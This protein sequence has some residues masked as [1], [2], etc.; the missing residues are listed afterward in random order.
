MARCFRGRTCPYRFRDACSHDDDPE[1]D[2]PCRD[3]AAS[4]CRVD[5]A[6]ARDLLV[7]VRR[8]ERIVEQIRGVLVP[9][10]M[11]GDVDGFVG[12]QIGAVPVP[13]I[14]EPIGERV[15]NCF[16]EQIVGV[17]VPQIMEAPVDVMLTTPQERVQ[18]RTHEQIV[19][20]SVPHIS[21]ERVPNRSPE[22]IMDFPVSLNM[23]A[24]AGI[25]RDI[26]LECVQNRSFV[27]PKRVFV[28]FLPPHSALKPYTGKVF[29]VKL[30]HHRDDRSFLDNVGFIR[31]LDKHNMP[32]L[33]DAMVP[34][35]QIAKVSWF[36]R[37]SQAAADEPLYRFQP[38]RPGRSSRTKLKR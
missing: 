32:R 16:P 4:S 17:P 25:V 21:E 5:A 26:Q 22:Q 34:P 11:K 7:R 29:T 23:E 12:E 36:D 14:W 20:S 15:Q 28:D 19:V 8:L 18:H 37:K 6:T 9:Q 2:P 27:R 33:G 30:R 31:G 35:L 3:V 24:Y 13:Q 10:I 38:K 1:E